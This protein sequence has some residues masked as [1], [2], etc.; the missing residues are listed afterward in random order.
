MGRKISHC[1]KRIRDVAKELAAA[2]YEM[3]M[4]SSSLV[5][6]NWKKQ[7]PG[8][9]DNPRK[10]EIAFV[11]KYWGMHI[12]AAR[13]T[14]T[15]LLT[16]PIDEKAKDEIMEILALDATLIRGRKNPATIAGVVANKN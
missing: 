16:S 8:F 5:W 10:L 1:H 14:L 11:S 15:R 6:H 7:H 9:A 13:A 4:S 2:T 3:L 12:P